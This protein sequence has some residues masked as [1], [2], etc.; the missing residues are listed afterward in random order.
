[1]F[2]KASQ[3]DP[4]NVELISL[5]GEAQAKAGNTSAAILTYEQAIALNPAA[6][7]EFKLL[8]DLTKR[9]ES[10]IGRKEL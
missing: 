6:N 8:G 1:M 3:L 5:L 2:E 10:R 4:K 7:K 9:Q